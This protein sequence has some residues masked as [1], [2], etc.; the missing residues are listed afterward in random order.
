ML[1]RL[2]SSW[3]PTATAILIVAA[4]LISCSGDPPPLEPV[5][6]YTFSHL[7]TNEAVSVR[8]EE[9][10]EAALLVRV[11]GFETAFESRL[12][13]N[14]GNVVSAVRL[15]YLRAGPVFHVIDRK[16][17]GGEVTV[18]PHYL[19]VNS[20]IDIRLYAL[21]NQSGREAARIQAFRD[22]S[23]ALQSTDDESAGEWAERL[24]AMRSA[25]AGFTR[26]GDL[27]E[28]LW[29]RFLAAYIQ[30][31]PLAEYQS[32]VAD[33]QEVRT[34]ARDAG[35]MLIELMTLQL[36]GQAL[37]ER[38]KRD[39]PEQARLKQ[40]RAQ[41]VLEQ[42]SIIAERLQMKFERAWAANTRG[43]GF[44]YLDQYD[45]AETWYR[46][47]LELAVG[48][49]DSYL[50]NLVLSNLALV[51]ERQGDLDGALAILK[52]VNG[53]LQL[54]G[55]MVELAFNWSELSRLYQR[56]FLFEESI[57]AQARALRV[58]TELDS[59]EGMGR[60]RSSLAHAY[61]AIGKRDMAQ[62]V[63]L[64]AM[65][66][67]EAANYGRGLRDGFGLLADIYRSQDRYESMADARARQEKY[68]TSAS[69]RARFQYSRGLDTQAQHPRETTVIERHF[70]EAQALASEAG[71]RGIELRSRLQRCAVLARPDAGLCAVTDLESELE[72]WMPQA[73]PSPAFEARYLM[74]LVQ[75]NSGDAAIAT[76]TLSRLIEDISWYRNRL[77]GVLGAWYWER[78]AKI[79]RS[80]MAF[81]LEATGSGPQA[82]SSLIALN[83]LL[84]AEKA[85]GRT[86][87]SP[88]AVD[89]KAGQKLRSLL[90]QL[91][92][93]D[94]S[95]R[96]GTR[97]A[98]DRELLSMNTGPI[99]DEALLTEEDLQAL[100]AGLPPGSAVL[101][102]FFGNDGSWTWIADR[103]GVR[104][105]RLDVS[106]EATS[107]LSRA[108]NGLR[109]IG[110]PDR[111]TDLE[112]AGAQLLSPFG[113]ELPGTVFLLT[114]GEL[115]GFPFDALRRGGRYV[116][117][118]HDVVNLMSLEGL[119]GLAESANQ[120][121]AWQRVFLAGDPTGVTVEL[122]G[123][124][125]EID[126]L[127]RMFN[128]PQVT[129][130]REAQLKSG[131]LQDEHYARAD[132]FHFAGHGEI[133]LE[134]P[135]LSRLMLSG[136][137]VNGGDSYLTPLEIGRVPLSADLV[138]LSACETTGVNS[139]QFDTNMG[140][141]SEFLHAGAGA[142]LASLWPVSDRFAHEF[143]EDFYAQ[144][145]QGAGIP[146]ALA[147][148]KRRNLARDEHRDTLYWPSFQLYVR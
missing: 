120:A 124:S 92:G 106:N 2:I 112:A 7:T 42:A 38:P 69:H 116:A 140:F 78:R 39:D 22:Y 145:L 40:D 119:R 63:M 111:D 74:A 34:Q 121:N 26:S 94:E 61:L 83:R 14:A 96:S 41:E 100:L 85:S 30:Y 6:D 13:D 52:A 49:E 25:A 71:E 36:E 75:M 20:R 101:A 114:V 66:D 131:F 93:A 109:V 81:H 62:S 53:R 59:A 77:P 110:N 99:A 43:M 17:A 70:A 95:E 67:M 146:G 65:D 72:N 55:P 135:E 90:A 45:S 19:N 27:A 23:R 125:R 129:V 107:H 21:P 126:A 89:R 142:V 132:L 86:A 32:A 97:Q 73:A 9:F 68:L 98:I 12:L 24:S 18:T 51:N 136:G 103:S 117:Q 1:R 143:M 48:L 123:A 4:G 29:A 56:L 138:V 113:D 3:R 8:I 82:A 139:F 122:P 115:A 108:R 84:N 60:S 148:A 118:D 58:W 137:D 10:E 46:K 130:I 127:S 44:Y 88:A 128:G 57:D 104:I 141:V 102:Y 105:A 16:S 54:S 31:F 80:Y 144:L 35:M 91:S 76:D 37:I 11:E 147:E 133:N 87:A 47:A 15:P 134:Y 79:F 50:R 5:T 33:A 64:E 28:E